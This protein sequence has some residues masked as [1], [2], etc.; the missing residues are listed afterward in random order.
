MS[1]LLAPSPADQHA[2]GHRPQPFDAAGESLVPLADKER[3]FDPAFEA[4]AW[5]EAPPL[6]PGALP[7]PTS[8]SL[9]DESA[10]DGPGAVAAVAERLR[11][12]GVEDYSLSPWGTSSGLYRF[13]CSAPWGAGGAYHRHFEA[14]SASPADAA[15]RVLADIERWQSSQATST[16]SQIR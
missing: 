14:I 11:Q 12:L 13:R 6:V 1:E 5:N 4:A 9:A 3:Q 16:A 15:Q 8:E 10:T 7:P 2:E